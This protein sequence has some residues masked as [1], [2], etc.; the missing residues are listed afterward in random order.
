MWKSSEDEEWEWE[1]L[2]RCVCCEA[3]FEPEFEGDR[4]CGFCLREGHDKLEIEDEGQNNQ[5]P[6]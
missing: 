5:Y 1:V 4:F 3:A 6:P 2:P